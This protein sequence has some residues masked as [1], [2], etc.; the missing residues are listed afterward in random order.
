MTSKEWDKYIN[1]KVILIIEDTP[2]PR[3][4]D[5]LCV[6]VDETHVWLQTTIRK[7]PIPFSRASVKRIDLNKEIKENDRER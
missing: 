5:G 4:R 6:D 3:K 2:F 1:K 7:E